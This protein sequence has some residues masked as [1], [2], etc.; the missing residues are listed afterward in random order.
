M[1]LLSASGEWRDKVDPRV[2]ERLVPGRGNKAEFLIVLSEQADLRAA[3]SIRGKREKGRYV[4]EQL[5]AVAGKT[6][7]P[8]L[9]ELRRAG[10]TSQPFWIANMV[11]S[12]GDEALVR[13][14]AER[15]DVRRVSSNPA[16]RMNLPAGGV[17][18]SRSPT[19]IESNITR[20][21]APEVWGLGYTGQGVVVGGQDT[22]YAWEH[23][24]L[25]NQYRGYDGTTTNH[26]YNWH[27]A[28]HSGGGGC[29]ADSPFPCD[30]DTHG[31]HT[32]GTLIGDDGAGNQ[33]GMAPGARWIGCRNMNQGVGTPATYA[34]CFQWFIAP[35][36]LNDL[37]PDPSLAPDVINNSW[38]CPPSE[39][40][41][42][43][44]VL[45][46]V[47]AA[48][49]AAGIVVVV[50]AGNNGSSCGSVND[51]PAIY[52]DSFSVGNLDANNRIYSS[53]SRG[54]VTVDGSQRMKPD[55]SAPGTSIRSSLPGGGY[56]YKTGTSMAAPHVAGLVAL[57]LDAHPGLRGEVDR[58]EQL[59]EQ[60]AVPLV[61]NQ[62]CDGW[63][64]TN[65][66]NHTFGWGLIDA[67]E[68]VGIEDPDEDNL[69]NWWEI[70]FGLDRN[71]ADDADLDPDEDGMTT[72]QEYFANTDPTNSMSVLTLL[73][74][75][76]TSS[77]TLSVA[78][79]SR[80]DGFDTPR[81][82]AIYRTARIPPDDWQSL[83]SGLESQGD[84]TGWQ[85]GEPIGTSRWF[86]CV[87]AVRDTNEV[88][89][90]IAAWPPRT[91]EP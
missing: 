17:T 5:R 14:L 76:I 29:G 91:G 56:G 28:I 79:K 12:W 31:T 32:M 26:H 43:V 46:N 81:Q 82:Y 70:I 13:K 41:T 18:R 35:T 2:L 51:P 59:I 84:E 83:A 27:D 53:S 75:G 68:A 62:V 23:P 58:I 21:R 4:F 40:C 39:G 19:T 7:P 42:D 10:V 66:P 45:S 60:T 38:G 37:N 9:E 77:G 47:V 61:T 85:G 86:Y 71:W 89:S 54:P 80:Q 74:L 6:Q 44:S 65:V 36:D 16:A 15:P 69:P 8:V 25:K 90:S 57:I 24:A 64:S 88:Y 63:S 30:D 20:T 1:P 49:R 78:W 52:E 34:E 67:V 22:G 87:A 3:A 73:S 48:A 55:I 11:W 72:R 33:I 50:S